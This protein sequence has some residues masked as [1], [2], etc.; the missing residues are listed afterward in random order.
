MCASVIVFDDNGDAQLCVGSNHGDEPSVFIACS[1]ALSRVSPVFESLFYRDA[2]AEEPSAALLSEN[3]L[4]ELPHDKPNSLAILLY[5]IH[6]HFDK[7]PT[8][9]SVEA[10]YDLT[11]A[12]HKYGASAILRPWTATWTRSIAVEPE[13]DTVT[14]F[15]AMSIYWVLGSREDFFSTAARFVQQ[16]SMLAKPDFADLQIPPDTIEHI[17]SIRLHIMDLLCNVFR[18]MIQSLLVVDEG[19]RWCH[20]ATW[21]GHHRCE[22]MILGSLMSGLSRAGLWPLPD[23]K[24][25]PF[26]VLDLYTKLG[27]VAVHDIGK[28]EDADHQGCNPSRHLRNTMKDIIDGIPKHLSGIMFKTGQ[29]DLAK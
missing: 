24:N 21:F 8:Q 9:L 15:K 7:V 16:A 1:R 23:P 17:V 14:L 10:L 2:E 26:S 4:V 25:I 18:D 27:G 13:D 19:P 28:A 6:C 11:A 5:A 3:R 20:H 22:S 12:A 29:L